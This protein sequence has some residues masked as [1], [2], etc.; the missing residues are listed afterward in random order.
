MLPGM[1]CSPLTSAQH[2]L[3]HGGEAGQLEHPGR[4]VRPQ[5][6]GA[7]WRLAAAF[8]QGRDVQAGHL[9]LHLCGAA[10]DGQTDGG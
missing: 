8:A 6:H 3:V 5:S 7:E 9:V 2:L 1:T 4:D 10:A